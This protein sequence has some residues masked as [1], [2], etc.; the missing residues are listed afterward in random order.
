MHM[1]WNEGR[2]P[3]RQ[4]PLSRHSIVAAAARSQR[5]ERDRPDEDVN[6]FL[7]MVRASIRCLDWHHSADTK[8]THRKRHA[9]RLATHL[10]RL[11][12]LDLQQELCRE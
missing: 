3:R 10:Y 8:R 9:R 4:L 11:Q 1:G 7:P 5:V 12:Q 2:R 6:K